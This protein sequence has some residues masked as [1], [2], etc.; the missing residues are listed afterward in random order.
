MLIASHLDIHRLSLF[1]PKFPGVELLSLPDLLDSGDTDGDVFLLEQLHQL[2]RRACGFSKVSSIILS[3]VL[4]EI[5]FLLRFSGLLYRLR[6][7]GPSSS[8]IF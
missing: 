4:S 5:R 6:P 8:M 1:D 3:S 2:Y 7:T